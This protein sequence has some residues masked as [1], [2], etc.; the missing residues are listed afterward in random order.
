MP[1][2]CPLNVSAVAI[3]AGL[4]TAFLFGFCQPSTPAAETY[5]SPEYLSIGAAASITDTAR[6]L[7]TGLK[8]QKAEQSPASDIPTKGVSDGF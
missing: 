3:G 2:F 6:S 5:T 7:Y 8:K 1:L 4:M